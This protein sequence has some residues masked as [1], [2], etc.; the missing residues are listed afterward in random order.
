[1]GFLISAIIAYL[2]GSISCAILASKFFNL[3][4]PRKDGS[5]NPG[6]TNV[7][8]LS[9][10]QAAIYVLLGDGLKGLIAVLIGRAFHLDGVALGFIALAVVLGH[11]F[12]VYFKF[13]GG[14]G[15]ATMIGAILGLTFWG[16]L[17]LIATWGVVAF[18]LRY[19]SLAS[20][21]TAVAA[22]IYM[23]ILSDSYYAFPV[24]LIT[25][26]VIWKHWANIE[27]LRQGKENKIKF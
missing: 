27:R 15:V 17:L 2:L 1:M 8:R 12:P 16:G 13:Q 18:I 9:G 4:D 14:K 19:S 25:V 20:V 10:K 21:V 11:V 6:A 7:L 24:F 5:G 22:P 3:P 23:L 26:L